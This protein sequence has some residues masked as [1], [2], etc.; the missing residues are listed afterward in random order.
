MAPYW[1][2]TDR[3]TYPFRRLGVYRRLP[4]AWPDAFKPGLANSLNNL[5]AICQG[6]RH[7]T[8]RFILTFAVYRVSGSGSQPAGG[9]G[10]V[11]RHAGSS[12]RLIRGFV[13]KIDIS[14]DRLARASAFRLPLVDLPLA[15]AA[16][17][18][19]DDRCQVVRIDGL[20][21]VDLKSS[22]QG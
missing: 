9:Y 17:E 5:G 4:E 7:T 3:Q 8:D 20:R 13:E 14:P 19:G 2:E 16:R 11:E 21:K 12:E 1:Q 6:N 10:S 18:P 15:A 22:Q